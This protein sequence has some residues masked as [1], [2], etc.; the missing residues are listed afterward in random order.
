MHKT[1][2]SVTVG[3]MRCITLSW[4]RFGIESFKSQ[5]KMSLKIDHFPTR[6]D[7]ERELQRE[8]K[9]VSYERNAGE[10]YVYHWNR[11]NRSQVIKGISKGESPYFRN[12][13]KSSVI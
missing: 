13:R 10:R 2:K 11:S 9:L 7:S 12:F 4:Q 3:I 1:L 8:N 5:M 6:L